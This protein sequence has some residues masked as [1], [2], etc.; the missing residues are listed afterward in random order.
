MN[1]NS[2]VL[3]GFGLTTQ[4]YLASLSDIDAVEHTLKCFIVSPNVNRYRRK[5]DL[6]GMLFENY[7]KS[8]VVLYNHNDDH[9][10]IGRCLWL[11][12]ENEGILVKVQFNN[13]PLALEIFQLYKEGYLTSWS[14]GFL[15][16]SYDWIRQ[17]DVEVLNITKWELVEF[18][19]VP[20]PADPDAVTV[21]IEQGLI[22]NEI[23]LQHLGNVTFSNCF[24][25]IRLLSEQ[26]HH[27]SESLQVLTTR[28]GILSEDIKPLLC[29][30]LPPVSELQSQLNESI[31]NYIKQLK[32]KAA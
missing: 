2:P 3:S 25:G 29:P 28:F 30:A 32:Q 8:P 7:L 5:V 18:S 15:P 20:V 10:P 6:D 22:K 19:A 12:K 31:E 16:V 17:D 23:L 21:A 4:N 11:K 13:T 27:L 14:I 24:A 9:L 26:V 1:S